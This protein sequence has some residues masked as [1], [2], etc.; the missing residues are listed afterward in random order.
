MILFTLLL[1]SSFLSPQAPE[2]KR[3]LPPLFLALDANQDGLIDGGELANAAAALRKLDLNG[4]GQLTPDEYRPPR[5]GEGASRPSG[6]PPA[7]SANPSPS[8]QGPRP[9]RPH[10]PRPAIDEALDADGDEVI[11]AAEISRATTLLKKLDLNGDGKLSLR[12]CG[13]Q[14]AA[15]PEAPNRMPARRDEPSR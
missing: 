15:N 6:P 14:H 2:A 9:S 3:P 10:H 4:D 7:D 12:E 8:A 11:S 5:P 13:P 1:C